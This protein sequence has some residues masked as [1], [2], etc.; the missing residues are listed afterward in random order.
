[1]INQIGDANI[2]AFAE[3]CYND[4]SA[5]ELHEALTE[6][7]DS[8]TMGAWGLT[9]EQYNEALRAALLEKEE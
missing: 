9:A 5:T 3:A 7:P 1:M 4:C 8:V 6:T 2:R